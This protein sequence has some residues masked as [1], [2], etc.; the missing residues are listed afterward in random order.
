MGIAARPIFALASKGMP[1]QAMEHVRP[2]RGGAQSHLMRASDGQFYVVKFLNNPQH[3]R[4]LANEWLGARL[5]HALG[6]PVPEIALVDVSAEMVAGSP[7]LIV[8]SAGSII[9]CATGLQF[10]SR[11]PTPSPNTPIYDYLPQPAL[12]NVANLADFAGMLVFDKWTCNC[13]GRQVIFC[14]TALRQPLR[15]YMVDQGFCFNAGDWNFPD[16]PLRGVFS[17]NVV[18]DSVTGWP[19]FEPWLE[20]VEQLDEGALYGF[21][22][23]MPPDWYGDWDALRRLLD[24]LYRRRSRIRELLWA[25][26]V[27]SRAPFEHWAQLAGSP[28]AEVT[29]G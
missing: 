6:L 19:S 23:E 20:R 21:G 26:K 16:S 14:R 11:L 27:S 29:L 5:A 15:V 2:M 28:L 3:P 1:V 4:V 25:V 17:K 22:E 7:G 24:Q 18:Y 13:N 9:P 12:D 10:G 8:R